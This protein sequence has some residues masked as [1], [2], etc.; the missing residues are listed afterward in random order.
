M[1]ETKILSTKQ[2]ITKI[3]A[4]VLIAIVLVAV[5]VGSVA[6]LLTRPGAGK[7]TIDFWHAESWVGAVTQFQWAIDQFEKENPDI[8]VVAHVVTYAE[9]WTKALAAIKAGNP[10]DMIWNIVDLTVTAYETGALVPVDDMIAELGTKYGGWI[11]AAITSQWW[12][13][14]YWGVPAWYGAQLLMYHP[15]ILQKYCNTTVPP[16]TWSEMLDY[17]E[18][19][20]NPP[21]S[22]GVGL[23]TGKNLFAQEQIYGWMCPVNATPFDK[24]GT[25][26]FDNPATVAAY[27]FYSD[28]AKFASP[29]SNTW[30]WTEMEQ[31]FPANKF[32]MGI[33]FP[34]GMQAMKDLG[35]H[36]VAIAPVPLPDGKWLEM[37]GIDAGFPNQC[38]VYPFSL[39]VFKEAVNRGHYEAVKK[40]ISFALRPDIAGQWMPT[41][42]LG[43]P[44]PL[45]DVLNSSTYW[46]NPY[47]SYFHDQMKVYTDPVI[48]NGG[49]LY[50]FEWGLVNKKIGEI[51]GA[52]IMAEAIEKITAG[53]TSPVDSVK[54]AAGKMADIVG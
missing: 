16:K 10:P 11:G 53:G 26:R 3:Q 27:T 46:N 21:D 23:S 2:A 42:C 5:I 36:D 6:Y 25:L 19:C 28:L 24:S 40:W 30:T 44:V 4:V 35:S 54:W 38:L 12:D 20:N 14:H 7:E 51:S 18:K 49:R 45:R 31:G 43:W 39:C 1:K 29:G 50:G 32:A 33:Y 48:M 22:Y 9:I 37:A 47:V 41:A 13:G 15:S 8:H 17:A 34:T 52:L